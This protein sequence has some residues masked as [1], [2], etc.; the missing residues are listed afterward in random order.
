[1]GSECGPFYLLRMDA[2]HFPPPWRLRHLLCNRRR[3]GG[4][5]IF[6]LFVILCRSRGNNI[7]PFPLPGG[8]GRWRVAA[9]LGHSPLLL[10]P[11]NQKR[12]MQTPLL[13][14]G[15]LILLFSSSLRHS[16]ALPAAFR[17][18]HFLSRFGKP[19]LAA[20]LKMERTTGERA[21]CEVQDAGAQCPASAPICPANWSSFRLR[22]RGWDW[23][24]RFLLQL[25]GGEEGE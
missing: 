4:K 14:G 9:L 11:G 20:R 21:R 7:P 25:W 24:G 12:E 15:R 1:M 17:I 18:P 19:D 10:N 3:L 6:H 22:S 23:P 13:Q 8:G 16:T 5:F 2:E